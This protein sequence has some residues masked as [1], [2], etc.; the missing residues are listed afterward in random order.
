MALPDAASTILTSPT[1]TTSSVTTRSDSNNMSLAFCKE[2]QQIASS[3]EISG[4]VREFILNHTVNQYKSAKVVG[5]V[6]LHGTTISIASE[7][8][9]QNPILASQ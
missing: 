6:N 3:I 1:T 7:T 5:F 8:F 9:H 4:P 2:Q